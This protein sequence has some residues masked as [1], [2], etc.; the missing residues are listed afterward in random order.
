MGGLKAI[1]NA[2]NKGDVARA[3]MAAVLL[4]IPEPPLLKRAV[5]QKAR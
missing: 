3:Q 1:S 2:L 4:G 5:I